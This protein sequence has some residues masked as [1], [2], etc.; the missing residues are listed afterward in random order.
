MQ[1]YQKC[2]PPQR[3]TALLE[4]LVVKD[5]P[6]YEHPDVDTLLKKYDFEYILAQVRH[7]Y[8]SLPEEESKDIAQEVSIS[9]WRKLHKEIVENP[10]AYIARMIRNKYIDGFRQHQRHIALQLLPLPD[11]WEV[12][13]CNIAAIPAEGMADPAKE[14]EWKVAVTDCLEKIIEALAELPPRQQHAT[15]CFLLDKADDLLQLLD[16]F[17]AHNMSLQLIYWPKDKA[18]KQLLKA[19]LY[20]ARAFIAQRL[21]IDLSLYKGK[22]QRAL[23][24]S[25]TCNTVSSP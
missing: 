20:P 1:K 10:R 16:A 12:L 7:A 22:K 2:N 18:D 6:P 24:T 3:T 14:L 5:F 13:E 8:P 9:F 11:D 25:D 15:A 19:S 21:H 17:Q 4:P 23:V